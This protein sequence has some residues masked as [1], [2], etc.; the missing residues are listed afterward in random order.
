MIRYTSPQQMTI[1]EFKTP[2]QVNIDRGNRW[3]ELASI[4]PW[5]AL[6]GI[7][8]SKEEI[9]ETK[10][11]DQN[12]ENTENPA[13]QNSKVKDGGKVAKPK[14]TLI[15]DATVA[16]QMIVYPTDLGLLS[17]SR[18]ESERLID[19]L[20]KALE[21]GEKPRTY[22]RKARKQYLLLA[23]KKNTL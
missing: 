20:C 15:V 4:L 3:V 22:R 17:R 23:K 6:A 16:D 13:S 1:E 7:Y 21:I 10:N 18:E 8:Y 5:D 9:Q 19:E 14:G 2:F 11:E 12:K